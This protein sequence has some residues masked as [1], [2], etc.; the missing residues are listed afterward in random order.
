LAYSGAHLAAYD[1]FDRLLRTAFPDGSGETL[2]YDA[3]G[4]VLTRKTRR[5]D[6][7]AF[8]YD[9][10][11]RLHHQL[12]RDKPA[13]GGELEPGRD[14]DRTGGECRHLPA[15]LRRDQPPHQPDRDRQKLVVL[16][17]EPDHDHDRL[18]CQQF[19]PIHHDRRGAPGL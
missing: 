9:T 14:A 13:A 18:R 8:T 7:I 10:L 4:N 15:R 5:G 2:G 11:N 12:G 17:G 19:E 16:P 1:G 6:T 3:D